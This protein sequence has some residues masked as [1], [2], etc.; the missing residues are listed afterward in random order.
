MGGD[1]NFNPRHHEV[2]STAGN[3]N[4][5]PNSV[6]AKNAV[7]V[8][9]GLLHWATQQVIFVCS[10]FAPALPQNTAQPAEPSETTA[11]HLS[12]G[13]PDCFRN[14]AREIRGLPFLAFARS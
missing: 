6:G 8:S 14:I 1:A 11:Q 5:G 9:T 13:S 12:D 7:P 10:L 3:A 2:E 4:T